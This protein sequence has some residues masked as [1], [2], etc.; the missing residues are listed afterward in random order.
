MA[1]KPKKVLY[2]VA[3]CSDKELINAKDAIKG[4]DYFCPVCNSSLILRKS[5]NTGRN[6]KR[7]H[8]AHKSLTQDCTPETALHYTFKTLTFKI[9]SDL[10]KEKDALNFQWGCKFCTEIHKGDLL[11]KI[12]T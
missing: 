11:K 6:S 9:I 4:N 7:P 2:S 10:L 1:V 5:G 12:V 3:K 8:F